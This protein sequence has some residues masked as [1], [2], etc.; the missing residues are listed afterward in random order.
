MLGRSGRVLVASWQVSGGLQ[1]VA[2]W[3]P[4]ESGGIQGVWGGG[5]EPTNPRIRCQQLIGLPFGRVLCLAF[6][7]FFVPSSGLLFLALGSL[8]CRCGKRSPELPKKTRDAANIEPWGG[9][10]RP[11]AQSGAQERPQTLLKTKWATTNA[12]DRPRGGPEEIFR[13]VSAILGGRE[14]RPGAL[15]RPPGCH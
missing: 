7:S 6:S 1:L 3:N 11:G 5:P 15:W 10:N 13:P 4:R 8:L 9:Q 2:G 14:S 12:L